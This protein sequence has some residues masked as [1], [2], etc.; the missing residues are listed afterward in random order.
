MAS[1]TSAETNETGLDILSNGFKLRHADA[2]Q[3]ANGGYYLYMAFAENSFKHTT[4][5]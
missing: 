5:R 2:H 3:N 4:A 1:H